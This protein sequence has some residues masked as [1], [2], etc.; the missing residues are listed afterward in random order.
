MRDSMRPITYSSDSSGTYRY[1]ANN[2]GW[3]FF[4]NREGPTAVA[5]KPTPYDPSTGLTELLTNTVWKGRSVVLED[6]LGIYEEYLWKNQPTWNLTDRIIPTNYVSSVGQTE[7]TWVSGVQPLDR[8]KTLVSIVYS[9]H[10]LDSPDSKVEDAFT[11]YLSTSTAVLEGTLITDVEEAGPL[12]RFLEAMSFSLADRV[13]EQAEINTLYDIGKC[14]EEFLELLG[15]LIG[16][17]FIGGDIDKWRVQLRNAVE[18]YKMKGTRRSIQY[19]LDTLFS[20]G[21]FNVTTSNTLSELWESYIPELMYYTLATSSAAF[22][23]LETYTPELALQFG[24]PAYDPNSLHTNIQY[25]VDKIIFDLVREFPTSF[26]MGGKP[27]PTPQLMLN[28]VP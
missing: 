22:E 23:N 4:L 16:W 2:L 26:F 14:P 7:E 6:T 3:L 24:I 15:E 20:T 11:T 28:G 21:V 25:V 19:L 12:A 18:I 10:F 5:G 1:L 13:T 27:F 8:L 9:P 17:K